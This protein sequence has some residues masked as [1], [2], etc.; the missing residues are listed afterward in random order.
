MLVEY[1]LDQLAGSDVAQVEAHISSCDSCR[2]D[3]SFLR[4]VRQDLHALKRRELLKHPSVENLVQYVETRVRL[5]PAA[6]ASIKRHL[7]FCQQCQA[8]V[9]AI[10]HSE[11]EHQVGE[12]GKSRPN[13]NSA[14]PKQVRV[15]AVLLHPIFGYAVAAGLALFI[16]FEGLIKS[17]PDSG[18]QLIPVQR[19]EQQLRSTNSRSNVFRSGGEDQLGLEFRPPS[20]RLQGVVVTLLDNDDKE[21]IKQSFENGFADSSV[22]Q[23]IVSFK[24]FQDGQYRLLIEAMNSETGER[25]RAAYDF[26]LVTRR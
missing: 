1:I 14:S 9:A 5:D 17:S 15:S 26:E 13:G 10:D 24:E 3:V 23:I 8:E 2:T 22:T 19:I 6:D 11:S 4:S 18:I 7:L 16:I 21:L 25:V 20:G 12:A